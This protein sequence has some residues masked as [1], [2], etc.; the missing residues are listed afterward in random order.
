MSMTTLVHLSADAL[1]KDERFVQV[2]RD[3]YR[4]DPG[5]AP[6]SEQL[7]TTRCEQVAH[8]LICLDAVVAMHG[9]RPVARAASIVEP[10]ATDTSGRPEGWIGLVECL[11]DS[12]D[13]GIAVLRDRCTW[14][15]ERGLSS[16]AAPRTAPL[17]GGV[18]VDGFDEPQA[19]L[20]PHNP[21]YYPTLLCEAGFRPETHLVSYRFDRAR[22]PVIRVRRGTGVFVRSI[23]LDDWR[24]ELSQLHSF[25]ESVFAGRRA[26]VPRHPEQ[27]ICMVER[28]R[29]IV[30]PDLVLLAEDSH[31]AVVGVLVCLPD[32]WQRCPDHRSPTRA[33]LM[34]I[35]LRPGW[36]GRGA[37]VAMAAELSTRLLDRGYVC[38]EASWIQ[39]DNTVPQA[40]ARAM[41]G[42]PSRSVAIYRYRA[43]DV[44]E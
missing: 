30:D 18:V 32:T 11:P 37:A 29:P 31:G 27:T 17:V 3:V 20:T 26:R 15:A 34:S 10:A 19:I 12:I 23:D 16:I 13:A 2:A 25:Q 33:R 43:P 42:T 24:R 38:L 14:L 9:T 40:L 39:Q 4:D 6:D 5:W 44:S 7:I 36:R 22:A 8:G 28:L 41:R 1:A 35:G 21:P